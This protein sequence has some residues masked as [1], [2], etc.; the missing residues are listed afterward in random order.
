MLKRICCIAIAVIMAL[1]ITACKGK[2]DVP[3]DVPS[4]NPQTS[5][6]IISEDNKK[7]DYLEEGKI[8]LEFLRARVITNLEP[9][10]V[11]VDF[12]FT[13]DSDKT[14]SAQDALSFKVYQGSNEVALLSDNVNAAHEGIETRLR[15]GSVISDYIEV[16]VDLEGE[17]TVLVVAA[18][19]MGDGSYTVS[20]EYHLSELAHEKT[21]DMSRYDDP[22]STSG[23]QPLVEEH[24]QGKAVF[25]AD[26]SI[27]DDYSITRDESLWEVRRE[28]RY[29]VGFT[30]VVDDLEADYEPADEYIVPMIYQ[31][32]MSA[33]IS[34][35]SYRSEVKSNGKVRAEIVYYFET[36]SLSPVEVEVYDLS[37]L[38]T[39]A[40]TS[41]IE[42]AYEG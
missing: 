19:S 39:P 30:V 6:T 27:E 22:V 26:I 2:E 18:Y 14:F 41:V 16:P 21:T 11:R 17:D 20:E 38:S 4:T 29:M 36:D 12:T 3:A 33:Q 42:L 23:E 28:E 34:N 9:K 10:R 35:S 13:N 37:D 15:P 32:G 24:K 40:V 7:E 8:K 25:G 5:E 1:S 31:N